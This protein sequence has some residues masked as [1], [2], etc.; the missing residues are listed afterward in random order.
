[1]NPI[2]VFLIEQLITA[3]F[4]PDTFARVEA[5]VLRWETSHDGLLSGPAKQAGAASEI[6]T[7]GI[8]QP[9]NATNLLIELAVAKLN[10]N[11]GN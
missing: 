3:L 10:A 6:A 11:K 2:V 8:A 5:A 9:G 1:M 4:S 7:L